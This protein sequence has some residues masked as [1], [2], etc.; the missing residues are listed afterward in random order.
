MQTGHQVESI[1]PKRLKVS[2][3]TLDGKEFEQAFDRL[4]IATGASV[5]KPELPGFDL[6]R[7]LPLKTL[8]DGRRIKALLGT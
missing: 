3:T 5:I 1:D 8:E 6:P 4:L 7:V 2:G